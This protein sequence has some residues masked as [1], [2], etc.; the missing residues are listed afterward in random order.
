MTLLDRFRTQPQKH[1]DPAVRL[2]YVEELPLSEHEQIVAAAREDDDARVRRAAVGKL[3]DPSV[4]AAIAREDADAGVRENALAM[5]R[6]IASDAF[7]GVSEAAGLAAV[8]ALD[9]ERI[10]AQ[11]AKTSLRESVGRQALT[12]LERT[13]GSHV[14]ASVARQAA[15]EP[16]RQ[17]ALEQLRDR[18]DI[19]VVALNSDY[20]DA[21]ATAVDRLVDRDDLEQVAARARNR[22]AAKRARQLLR[23][24]DERVAQEIVTAQAAEADAASAAAAEAARAE[25]EQR[26][27]AAEEAAKAAEEARVLAEA[28]ALERSQEEAEKAAREVADRAAR[29]VEERQAREA[30]ERLAQEEA[31]KRRQAEDAE[32]KTR[33]D[34]LSRMNQLI[35]RVEALAAREDVTLKAADR[36]LRDVRDALADVPPLPSRKDYDEV[37]R[38]LKAASAALTPKVQ[39]LREVSEWQRWANVGIQE[40][41]CEKMEALRNEADPEAIAR[42]IH[43]LQ[44][45]WRLAA[46]VPR[47]QGEALWRRFKTAHDELWVRC[48]AHFAAQAEQRAGNLASKS[49]LCARVE[50][51]ADSSNW[52][53]TAEE[54]KG[55]QA[56]WKT[57]GP[58]TR[59]QEKA[60]W[61]RFRAACDRFFTR[62]QEDLVKRKAMWAEN[63]GRKEA[64]CL[65]VEALAESTDWEQTASAI[66]ALQ[67]EWKTI[68]PVK[69]SRSDAIWQRFRAGC[70][71][72]FTRYAHRHEVARAERIAAR[73]AICAELE[74]LV[75]PP[76]GDDATAPEASA[77]EPP[78]E[79]ATTVRTL[80]NRW[81]QELAA[82]G[83]DRDTAVLLDRR[84]AEACRRVIA[85]W[86]T[87]FKG[88]DLDP[89][90]NRR[91]METLVRRVEEIASSLGTASEPSA[92]MSPQ[93][94]ASMLKE[95]LAANTIGGKV[96]VESRRRAAQEEAR[97]AQASWSR[98]GH[99][100]DEERRVLADRFQRALRQIAGH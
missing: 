43:D 73:E 52:V 44:Q 85:R 39:D 93:R 29:D 10:L 1:P 32:A 67:A 75:P 90:A 70:D 46:D 31:A 41:L 55:L 50:A 77:L 36:A 23:E 61:E 3:M 66:R 86:P 34:G 95:A 82:R 71:K 72:F 64:I 57:I 53:Q 24:Q 22:I 68:G 94:L 4:L 91:R 21:A 26:A 80:R 59:G 49:A 2:A 51:L 12:R 42:R 88:T 76:S 38:R 62:R 6:D 35:G 47:P 84:Y 96:D 58:V 30:A 40:Q 28:Q 33:R 83:V 100:A 60:I 11:I 74:A 27:R 19:L 16:I 14:L 13:G 79:L 92:E 18:A 98:I 48:E 87:G 15:L 20:K 45:Q 5:L 7:E 56:Q 69:K 63:F 89:E 54:I 97:Q 99:V 17:S 78:P 81:Q 8:D 65:K 37:V 9:D 25:Q